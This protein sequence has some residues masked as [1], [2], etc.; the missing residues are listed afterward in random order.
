MTQPLIS[1]AALER[2]L[3]AQRLAA[4]RLPADRDET[5]GLARYLWNVALTSAMQPAV[6]ALEVTFRNELSRA[7]AKL[8]EGR[9]FRYGRIPSWLDAVPTMLLPHEAEKVERA[10]RQLGG[11]PRSQTEGHLI[12]KLDFGFWVALCR[13]PYADTRADGPRL[14]PRALQLAFARRPANVTTRAEIFHR[15]DRIRVFRNRLAHHEP[16]WDRDYLREHEHVVESLAW[17]SPKLADAVRATSPAA[18]TFRRGPAAYR[19]HAETLL[20]TGPGLDALTVTRL[21]KLGPTH[22]AAVDSLLDAL[23]AAPAAD[24][25]EVIDAWME[26][27]LHRAPRAVALPV[28]G[29]I[30]VRA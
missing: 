2:S 27:S 19:P 18:E 25:V 6:H 21:R 9:R 11:D 17:M 13:E 30:G 26:R 28:M 3:S 5:D 16:V 23:A 7:A 1:I 14:W 24:P 12:G 4:Y 29:F 22:G 8:T 20:G 15:F 10:K